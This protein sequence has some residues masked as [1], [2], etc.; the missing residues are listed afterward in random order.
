MS[1]DIQYQP[2]VHE[3][4][5]VREIMRITCDDDVFGRSRYDSLTSVNPASLLDVFMATQ[6]KIDHRR[7]KR[8]KKG[9]FP[10]KKRSQKKL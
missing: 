6:L 4:E 1:E 9:G 8:H 2:F 5:I 3:L 10:S 7:L